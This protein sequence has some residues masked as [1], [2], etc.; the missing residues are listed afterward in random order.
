M[1]GIIMWLTGGTE[2]LPEIVVVVKLSLMF[3]AYGLIVDLMHIFDKGAKR[4]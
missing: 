4:L 1:D 3:Y 2:L